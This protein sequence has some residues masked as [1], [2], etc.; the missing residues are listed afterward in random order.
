[1]RVRE[2]DLERECV[3]EYGR[4]GESGECGE[5]GSGCVDMYSLARPMRGLR[6]SI[7]CTNMDMSSSSGFV[8]RYDCVWRKSS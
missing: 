8:D 2:R 7:S 6:A 4:E 5:C 1:M 3:L